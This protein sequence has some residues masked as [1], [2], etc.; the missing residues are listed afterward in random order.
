MSSHA[1]AFQEA[2]K[3]ASAEQLKDDDGLPS[4]DDVF[5]HLSA[6]PPTSRSPSLK[7]TVC[8]KT[9]AQQLGVSQ[10]NGTLYATKNYL[11]ISFF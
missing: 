5:S 8:Q 1:R 11:H 7:D 3:E 10:N 6:L 9:Y 4:M 2:Y